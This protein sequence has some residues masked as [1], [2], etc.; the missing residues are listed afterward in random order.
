MK[1]V[2]TGKQGM[3]GR[4]TE[5]SLLRLGVRVAQDEGLPRFESR[6]TGASDADVAAPG[7]ATWLF[8]QEAG[9]VVHCAAVVGSDKC[10]RDPE[11]AIRSNVLG[12]RAVVDACREQDLPLLFLATTSSSDPRSYGR[13]RPI[14]RETPLG[15]RTHYAWT[16]A[17][18]EQYARWAGPRGADLLIVRPCFAFGGAEDA[19]SNVSKLLRQAAG[20]PGY[21]ELELTVSPDALKDYTWQGDVSGAVAML[22]AAPGR[23][24]ERGGYVNVAAGRPIPSREVVEAVERVTGK[25]AAVKWRPDLDYMGDH[26]MDVGG[27]W[28]WLD[29]SPL[30]LEEGISR[31]WEAIRRAPARTVHDLGPAPYV[32]MENDR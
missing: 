31:A 28:D 26:V 19:M 16:K 14:T 20:H 6:W 17:C 25:C 30:P 9:V 27:L 22:A 8:M 15:P 18:G 29:H 5:E 7:W 21:G 12:A 13:D 3:L 1:A 23:W 2:I 4:G 11:D 32:Y 24:A 10:Q